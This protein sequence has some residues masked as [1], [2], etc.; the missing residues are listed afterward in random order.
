MRPRRALVSILTA[1]IM[2]LIFLALSSAAAPRSWWA[3][4]LWILSSRMSRSIF[5]G[6][7]PYR[8]GASPYRRIN[9]AVTLSGG[10]SLEE[11]KQAI[12]RAEDLDQAIYG[13]GI[14]L[15]PLSNTLYL[16]DFNDTTLL[17]DIRS[18]FGVLMVGCVSARNYSALNFGRK[19]V[20]D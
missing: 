13:L 14:R 11:H 5:G 7:A 12:G 9:Y 18:D 16:A 15:I 17:D 10:Y 19:S 1:I 20:D 4:T 3:T 6:L 2:V 8:C